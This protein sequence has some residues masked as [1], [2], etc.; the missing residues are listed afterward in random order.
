MQI[1]NLISAFIDY[2]TEEL[3][4]AQ[5]ELVQL[6]AD[7]SLLSAEDK[8]GLTAF[9]DGRCNMDLLDWQS[10]YDALF[11][12]GRSLSLLLFEHIHGESRDRGQAMIDLIEQYK[13]AGLSIDVRELPDY[14]PLF[15]EFVATQVSTQTDEQGNISQ[16]YDNARLWLQDVSHIFALLKVRLGQRDSDYEALFTALVHLSQADIQFDELAAQVKG[17]KRD[18]TK[19][20]IDKVWEEEM[21]KFGPDA[22][23][24]GCSD[25]TNRPSQSQRRDQDVPIQFIEAVVE[26]TLEK[27]TA[28]STAGVN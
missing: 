9:V 21:V 22:S 14:I 11:E 7:N 1:L 25:A 16:N 26:E 5:A 3:H 13:Q 8:S 17:E 6:I 28:K 2:P 18:D 10:D 4:Q 24:S 23:D 15:L 12:R 20:A 19:E 27:E